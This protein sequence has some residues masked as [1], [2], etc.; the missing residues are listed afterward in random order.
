MSSGNGEGGGGE[1][2]RLTASLRISESFFSAP[3][4]SNFGPYIYSSV[5][6]DH[7]LK[8]KW[9]PY[10]TRLWNQYNTNPIT[11]YS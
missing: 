11:S 6:G 10:N 7:F 2:D 4:I 5:K 1:E 3:S 9:P 8:P